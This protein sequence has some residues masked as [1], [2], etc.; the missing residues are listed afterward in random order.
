MNDFPV[1]FLLELFE[2]RL[3]FGELL[4]LIRLSPMLRELGKLLFKSLTFGLLRATNGRTFCRISHRIRTSTPRKKTRV[5]FQEV[6]FALHVGL[7][8]FR[9]MALTCV[10][11]IT[12]MHPRRRLPQQ[13]QTEH[14]EVIVLVTIIPI[15]VVFFY[16]HVFLQIRLKRRLFLFVIHLGRL[17][18]YFIVPK[19]EDA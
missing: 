7:Q 1:I 9:P 13:D 11:Q 3:S 12:L 6:T 2:D 16:L 18:L 17:V 8:P 5:T 10:P 4:G 19:I 14:V 15:I